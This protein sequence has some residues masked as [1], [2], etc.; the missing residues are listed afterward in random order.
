MSIF[1]IKNGGSIAD[2]DIKSRKVSGY[3]A[4]FGNIDHDDDIFEK[5]AFAKTIK[6]RK[7]QMFFLHQH[8]WSKPLG[9]F[10]ELIED[11]KGLYFVANVINTTYGEDLLKLYEAE[12]VAQHSVGFTTIKSHVGKYDEPRIIKEVQL[13]EGSAVTLG[14]NSNTPYLGLKSTITENKSQINKIMSV[15]KSGNLTDETFMQLELALKMLHTNAFELGK[16]HSIKQ[17]KPSADTS[18]NYEPLIN[19]I[20]NFK[21]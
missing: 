1:E 19:T 3:L 9:K 8:D 16:Q 14:A 20:N 11:E 15:L 21:L 4:S 17:A 6:E 13:Y 7:E 5:G 18:L 10:D 12:I 2:I